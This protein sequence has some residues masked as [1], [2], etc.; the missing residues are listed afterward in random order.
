MTFRQWRKE[1]KLNQIEAAKLLGLTQPAV[2]RIEADEKSASIMHALRIFDKS[3]IR[4]GPLSEATG[5]EIES[6]RKFLPEGAS[7]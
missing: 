2:S 5:P 1:R 3:G 7:A 4:I 6:L